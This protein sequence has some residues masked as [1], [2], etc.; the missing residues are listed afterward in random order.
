MLLSLRLLYELV[1]KEAPEDEHLE[2]RKQLFLHDI[3]D[4]KSG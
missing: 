4:D 2:T 3:G 1:E